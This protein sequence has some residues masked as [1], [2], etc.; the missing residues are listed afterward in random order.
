MRAKMERDKL[1]RCNFVKNELDFGVFKALIMNQKL[2]LISRQQ[3]YFNRVKFS[4]FYSR[5][6]IK[7]RCVVTGRSKSYIRQFKVSR[8]KLREFASK[9]WLYGVS[10]SSW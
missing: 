9:G 2:G 5:T 7:N 8:I 1:L 4:P 10:K 3:I 6:R